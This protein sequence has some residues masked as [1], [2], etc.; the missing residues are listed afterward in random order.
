[1]TAL[2]KPEIIITHESDLDG[3]IAGLLLLKLA[4]KLF[5]TDI[6]LAPYHYNFWKQGELREKSAWVTDF[7]FEARM[8]KPDWVVI[9]HHVTDVAPKNARRTADVY[10]SA[11]LLCDDFCN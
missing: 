11:P 10:K 6:P 1:M 7:R 3:L 9:D 5:G 4:K 2:P 8:D